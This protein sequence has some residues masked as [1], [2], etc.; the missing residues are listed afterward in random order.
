MKPAKP[1]LR[2]FP[3][4]SSSVSGDA[5]T[6]TTGE[7]ARTINVRVSS[8]LS[9]TLASGLA[10]VDRPKRAKDKDDLPFGELERDRK[11]ES[12]LDLEARMEGLAGRKDR[13]EPGVSGDSSAVGDLVFRTSSGGSEVLLGC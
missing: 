4:T 12:V 3:R 1:C 13:I 8:L 2:P 5:R 11:P 6:P 7:K 9:A 10:V